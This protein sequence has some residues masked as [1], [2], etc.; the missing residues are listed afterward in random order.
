MSAVMEEVGAG[1]LLEP[2]VSTGAVR[3]PDPHYGSQAPA[4]CP[5][6]CR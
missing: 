1:L 6:S 5:H 2:Y 4:C 3:R